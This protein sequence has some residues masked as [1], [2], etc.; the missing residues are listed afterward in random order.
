MTTLIPGTIQIALEKARIAQAAFE[1]YNQEQ[2]DAIVK[3]IAKTVYDNAESLAKL[4][5][6]ETG[7]GV[8]EDKVAKNKGKSQVIW[9][10]LKN[11]KSVGIIDRN[12]QTGIIS[13]AKPM[14]VVGSVTPVTN[15]TVT[16][17]SNAMFALKG[18]NAIIVAPH[19]KAKQASTKAVE[20]INESIRALGAPE[21]LIQI[22]DVCST[23]LTIALMQAVDVV[24]ATGGGAMVKSA[25]SS[26]K[27]AYGVGPGNVQVILDRGID[28][29]DAAKKIVLGRKF[30]NGII[31][32][33]EQ[34][35]IF[36][37]DDRDAVIKA[38]V[39][40]GAYYVTNPADADALRATV[41]KEGHLNKDVVGQ[42]VAK[43]ADMAGVKVTGD[44]KVIFIP[45]TGAP[46]DVLRYEKMCPVITSFTYKNL[47]EAIAIA[48]FNLSLEGKG[49]SCAVHSIN[50]EN[51]E[52]IAIGVY[53]SRVVVNQPSSLSAGGSYYNGFAPTTTLGCGSWG[54]NSISENLDYKHLINIQRIGMPIN[55]TPPSYDEL[56][57]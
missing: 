43:I 41:F 44:A 50:Q 40:N 5:L 39:E 29:D 37:E 42:S 49:H 32:S 46:D 12:E 55:F 18:R 3:A 47:D 7:M 35:V 23:E 53:T 22:L 24:V 25:Y 38:L 51:I 34:A 54:N 15:P 56:W 1:C 9:Q 27:P 10:H 26:G 8:Y 19:P 31:C 28:F 6:D 21:N 20:L 4:A 33:G 11:K 57:S 45:S 52:A 13:I 48:N 14:G 30:D 17:M 2:V 36:H 16:P